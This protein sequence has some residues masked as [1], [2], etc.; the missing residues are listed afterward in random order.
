MSLRRAS[1]LLAVTG[2]MLVPAAA[3][4]CGADDA[5]R[6]E[7]V[8]ASSEAE[9]FGSDLIVE[10]STSEGP[11]LLELYP[12]LAPKHVDAF[13][14]RAATGDYDGLSFHRV[15]PGYL[16]QTGD[17]TGIGTGSDEGA[18]LALEPN[19][20]SHRRGTLSMARL[21]HP[22]TAGSQFFICHG[23]ADHLDG[24]YTAFGRMI[25]GYETLDAIA[26]A[27]AD[28]ERPID[29]VSL[30]SVTVRSRTDDDPS[31]GL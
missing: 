22:D 19:D 9:T 29:P 16:V 3:A 20:L 8:A 28:G 24:K 4:G 27:P 18:P 12:S 21:G 31:P 14:A 23:D 1:S 17:P 15:V 26:S 30:H 10:L 5:D 11:M 6:G 13:T 2:A 25:S 7:A